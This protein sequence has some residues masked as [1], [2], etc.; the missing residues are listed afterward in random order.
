[1]RVV[2]LNPCGTMGGAEICLMDMLLSVRAAE[3]GWDLSLVLGKDGPLADHARAA[4]VEVISAP[5]PG[6]LGRL[7]DSGKG[8]LGA[9]WSC[10]RATTEAVRYGRQLGRIVADLRPDV[11]HTNGF[12]M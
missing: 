10:A 1:M 11:I 2:Y 7:G 6:P 8:P 12:K 9:L 3:P 5:F 4:G